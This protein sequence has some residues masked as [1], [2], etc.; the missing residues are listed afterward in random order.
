MWLLFE[1]FAFYSE[2]NGIALMRVH[3]NIPRTPWMRFE[4]RGMLKNF[5]WATTSNADHIRANSLSLSLSLWLTSQPQC[6]SPS[7]HKLTTRRICQRA[8]ELLILE[9]SSKVALTRNTVSS[10]TA[11]YRRTSTTVSG[12]LL[13]ECP[14][15]SLQRAKMFEK[16]ARFQDSGS[17]SQVGSLLCTGRLACCVTAWKTRRI[18]LKHRKTVGTKSKKVQQKN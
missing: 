1:K 5:V 17:Y 4:R 11:F 7:D 2:S 12:G 15:W 3:L 13:T 18:I 10:T 9:F 6:H 14:R 8:V 16:H